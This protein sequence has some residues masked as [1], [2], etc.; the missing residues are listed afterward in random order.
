MKLGRKRQQI[1]SSSYLCFNWSTKQNLDKYPQ[2]YNPHYERFHSVSNT[3]INY[4]LRWCVQWVFCVWSSVCA[5][6]AS[7]VILPSSI[8]ALENELSICWKRSELN[9]TTHSRNTPS[10]KQERLCTSAHPLVG[11]NP[12]LKWLC[13]LF[14]WI[15]ITIACSIFFS[16]AFILNFTKAL[17]NKQINK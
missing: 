17:L 9:T 11:W 14:K 5:D 16:L 12:L 6:P 7:P 1:V 13:K 10:E 2:Y 15:I 3:Y 8:F 4:F